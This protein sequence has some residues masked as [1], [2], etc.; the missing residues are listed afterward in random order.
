MKHEISL[1]CMR[2]VKSAKESVRIH[3]NSKLVPYDAYLQQEPIN[4]N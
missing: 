3:N 1:L 2:V 4:Q